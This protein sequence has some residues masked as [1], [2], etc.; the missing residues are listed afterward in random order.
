MD[1]SLPFGEFDPDRPIAKG[2][3]RFDLDGKTGRG[4]RIRTSGADDFNLHY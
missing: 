2:K 4:E 1:R 3:I